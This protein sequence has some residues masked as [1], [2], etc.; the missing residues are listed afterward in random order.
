MRR[1]PSL[2]FQGALG[3]LGY[4]ER[5]WI[6][7]LD[8]ALG[9]VILAAGVAAGVA[10]VG[11]PALAPAGMF[12][13]VWG[14]V[15]QKGVAID[16][17]QQAVLKVSGKLATTKGYE[18]RQ[19][20][21]AAHTTI[22]VAAFFEV[23]KEEIGTQAFGE[24]GISDA[25]KEWLIS[26]IQRAD[27][28]LIYDFLYSAEVPAP[29]AALGF[30]ENV[31]R[32]RHWNGEFA[33]NLRVFLAGLTAAKKLLIDWRTVID[34][35]AERYRS[36]F[37]SLAKTVPDFM[38][39]ASLG[40]HAATR[41]AV[42]RIQ[43][44]VDKTSA[45]VTDT[46]EAVTEIRAT[47]TE[48]R[49]DFTAALGARRDSLGRVEALLGIDAPA[50][51]ALPGLRAAVRRANG[52]I[53]GEPI[54]PADPKS[55]GPDIMFPTVG[56]IYVDPRYRSAIAHESARPAD[57]NWWGKRTVQNDFDLMLAGYVTSP[58]ATR[59]PMLLL[60]HPGAGK[61]M[62]TKVL[63]ARLPASTYTVVRVPLRRVGANAPLIDQIQEGLDL[64]TNR[65]VEWWQLAEQ[66][67][68][69][70]RVVLLDGLDELL[71]ASQQD[72]SGYLQEVMEFQRHED[73]QKQPVVVI[74]TSRTVVADRV[75]IPSGVTMVKL[76]P[77]DDDDIA[78][79]LGRWNRI[80]S[81]VITAGKMRGLTLKAACG[82]LELSRQPLLLLMLALYAA[83]PSM[84]SLEEDISTASLYGR[85]MDKFAHREA[86]KDSVS[87]MK[88]GE[89]GQRVQ[90]HLDRLAIAALA[91]FNRGRQD[92]G[93]E[94]LG[95][96]LAALDERLM[97]RSR[98]VEAGQRIIGEFFFVHA[99]EARTFTGPSEPAPSLENP[100]TFQEPPRRAYEFLHATF[101]EY[102]VARR[103]M[104]ELIE[105]ADKMFAS[106]RGPTAP[107]D[108]LLYALLCHQPLAV[109][110]S[111]LDFMG[112]I[113]DNLTGKDRLET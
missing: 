23:L 99:P 81:V 59:F 48:I 71:Q 108:D 44:N 105:V 9:G 50:V 46:N 2:T 111:T 16:L 15:E 3:I 12:A 107:D 84:P 75:N 106:R 53:L 88:A 94:E 73:E 38:I 87:P 18:R 19:L 104:D 27:Q 86:A 69:T 58:D 39:W 54:I 21:A 34:L 60:G 35:A 32:I 25:E 76:D 67:A 93:E 109:R 47:L 89:L 37:L 112:E 20:I 42:A 4:N 8:N 77:F 55:Y 82:Q 91:M 45:A 66:S 29:S 61:S 57:D 17:L 41:E 36:H 22:V 62:L 43:A 49:A 14:W 7:K 33:G 96:D 97:A 110:R 5:G 72:R 51:G 31:E 26:G 30:E 79:W 11:P 63:A 13:A 28:Q 6:K 52:G 74:V 64:A 101:G 68:E 56:E 83:D 10:A 103:V 40:E 80:N 102:L 100:S 90:D 78:D 98:P 92:I 85:L 95:T 65:R 70:V 1:E 24:L 113:C